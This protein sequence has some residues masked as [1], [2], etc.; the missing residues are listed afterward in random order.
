MSKIGI[1]YGTT[2]GVTED[3]AN[4]IADRLDGADVFNIA[5]NEDKQQWMSWLSLI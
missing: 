2:T 5:G 4:K 1:F 3:A